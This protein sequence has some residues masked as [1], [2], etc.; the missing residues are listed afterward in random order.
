MSQ[1]TRDGVAL[2]LDACKTLPSSSAVMRMQQQVFDLLARKLPVT[3]TI[4]GLQG[5][6]QPEVLFVRACKLLQRPLL[7]AAAATASLGIALAGSKLSPQFAFMVRAAILGHGPC[8]LLPGSTLLRPASELVGRRRQER[9]WLQC[10]HLRGTAGFGVAFAPGIT[11]PCPLFSAEPAA[12]IL[13]PHGL[14]VPPGTAW[15]FQQVCITDYVG[16]AG[17]LRTEALGKRLRSAVDRGDR[18]HDEQ[19]W[20][21]AAMRHDSWSNRRL[22][23]SITGIGDLVRMRGA[24][25]RSLIALQ[26][27]HEVLRWIRETVNAR[28]RE[29]AVAKEHAP[30]LNIAEAGGSI[31]TLTA[32]RTQWQAALQ[33]A[34][35]RHRNL[36]AISLWSVFP[37]GE[38]ADLRYCDLLPVLAGA[39]SCSFGQPPDLGHWNVN[40]FKYFHQRAWAVLERKE[41]THVIAERV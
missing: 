13:P 25:P 33:F 20:P 24:D 37:A 26:E 23:I 32:W 34:A 4:E 11:S 2:R 16:D 3:V 12:G 17:E 22:A 6:L 29:L 35:T 38:S 18:L 7:D 31:A 28:S 21:T 9:F 36:L 1:R 19:D 27:L 15:A 8:H 10:W 39:D 40:E 41:A 14:Q 30:A 5:D